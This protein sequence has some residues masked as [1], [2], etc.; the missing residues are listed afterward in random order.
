MA[1]ESKTNEVKKFDLDA[2]QRAWISQSLATQRAV[3]V[4]GLT[5]ERTGSAIYDLR[6][7]EIKQIEALMV[8]FQ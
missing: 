5:K 3:L 7:E 2:L 1:N 6:K 4:R 8:V